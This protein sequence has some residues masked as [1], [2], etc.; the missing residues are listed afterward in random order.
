MGEEVDNFT[1]L[2]QSAFENAAIAE[3]Y[4]SGLRALSEGTDVVVTIGEL[5]DGEIRLV[6]ADL[7]ALPLISRPVV[8]FGRKR[9]SPP[10]PPPATCSLGA[11]KMFQDLS[12]VRFRA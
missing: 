9:S 1:E 11:A 7:T 6:E 5:A 3:A 12:D 4:A 2:R 8:D 10:P